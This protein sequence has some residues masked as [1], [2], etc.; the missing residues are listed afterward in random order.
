MMRIL[1]IWKVEL[2][3]RY[4]FLFF[5]KKLDVMFINNLRVREDKVKKMK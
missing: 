5:V 2:V 4:V 3:F 1:F